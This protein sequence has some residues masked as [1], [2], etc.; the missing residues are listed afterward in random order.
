MT[1]LGFKP[2]LSE[3]SALVAMPA[4]LRSGALVYVDVMSGL[5]ESKGRIADL[6][7]R[8]H[9]P[10][11]EFQGQAPLVVVPHS[12]SELAGPSLSHSVNDLSRVLTSS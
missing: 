8:P 12:G 1:E 7:H 2:T 10:L 4:S 3:S 5:L 9:L 11:L 6:F